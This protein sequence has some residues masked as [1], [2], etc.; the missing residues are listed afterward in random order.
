MTQHCLLCKRDRPDALAD[1][2]CKMGGFCEWSEEEKPEPIQGNLI[3][4]GNPKAEVTESWPYYGRGPTPFKA[5]LGFPN[6]WSHAGGNELTLHVQPKR[7][8]KPKGLMLFNLPLAAE[9][10]SVKVCNVELILGASV[11]ASIFAQTKSYA[12]LQQLI[13][14]EVYEPPDWF[15]APALSPENQ[16]SISLRSSYPITAPDDIKAAFW[17]LAI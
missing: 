4:R 11:Q 9:L 10:T 6:A 7:P 15:D 13:L 8:F 17:G 3:Y 16:A 5:W 12:E 14:D 1:Q 2:S